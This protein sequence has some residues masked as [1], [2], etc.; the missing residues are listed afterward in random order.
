M[1]HYKDL[2]HIRFAE[3][4]MGWTDI[5]P[6]RESGALKFYGFVHTGKGPVRREI[7]DYSNDLDAMWAAEQY[8]SRLGMTR[9]YIK[10]LAVVTGATD[11]SEDEDLFRLICASPAQRC[12]AGIKAYEDFGAKLNGA[13]TQ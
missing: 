8:L 7:P 3:H 4:V 12:E 9:A 11:L 5:E 13:D 2:L 6:S 10:A 1:E